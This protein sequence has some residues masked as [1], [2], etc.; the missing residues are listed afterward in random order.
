MPKPVRCLIVGENPGDVTSEYFYEP[1]TDPRRDRVRVR[2]E[3]LNG[4]HRVGLITEPTLE[5][6]RDTGFLRSRNPW[7][8]AVGNC[9][10]GTT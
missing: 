8:A 7:P 6:F 5:A 2:R 10:S 4:L 1:P 9:E 3:L